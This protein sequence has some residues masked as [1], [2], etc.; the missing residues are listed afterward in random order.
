MLASVTDLAK[1]AC[2]H[3]TAVNPGRASLLN[4]EQIAAMHIAHTAGYYGSG[5]GVFSSDGFVGLVSDG[6]VNGGQAMIIL[7]PGRGLGVVVV[8]NVASD[9]VN[10]FAVETLDKMAP[11][12][13]SAFKKSRDQLGAAYEAT[14]KDFYPEEGD[15][16]LSGTIDVPNSKPA[17][18]A[19]RRGTDMKI[20]IGK[21]KARLARKEESDAG[22]LRWQIACATEL[23]ACTKSAQP[24]AMFYLTRSNGKLAGH[25][26]VES[27][28]GAFPYALDAVTYRY[29]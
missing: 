13:E 10:E 7:E 24:K 16:D 21:G 6:Q 20:T 25:I 2:F 3:L 11:G 4:P 9:V 12:F 28:L 17:F 29:K 23:P 1:Y 14:L 5:W 19:K 8:S 15:F 26:F 22:F 27:S 18:L